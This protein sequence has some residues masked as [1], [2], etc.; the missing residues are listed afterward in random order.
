MSRLLTPFYQ[1][2]SRSF[3][4]MRDIGFNAMYRLPWLPTQMATTI[5]G[6]KTGA[7]RKMCLDDIR[8]KHL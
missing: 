7:F 2:H 4:L 3:G 6:T 8:R 1:S 5:S